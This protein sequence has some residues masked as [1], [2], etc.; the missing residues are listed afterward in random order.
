MDQK[1]FFTYSSF[2]AFFCHLKQNI[3]VDIACNFKPQLLPTSL[4]I[5]FQYV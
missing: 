2:N 4:H 5:S 3:N 1:H